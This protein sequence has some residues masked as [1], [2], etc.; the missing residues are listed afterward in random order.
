MDDKKKE[1]LSLLTELIKFANADREVR[2]S[3]HR[4]LLA[5]AFQLGISLEEFEGLFEANIEFK[6]PVLEADRIVQLQRFVLLMNVDKK[7]HAKELIQIK[8]LGMKLGLHPHAVQQV[9]EEMHL[10]E[11]SLI[12]A[13][14]LIEIFK[15]YHN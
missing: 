10:H 6:P 13:Q 14:R 1:T 5:I 7:V 9:L 11:H 2:E 15:V 4:F 12:P 3:E 8:E